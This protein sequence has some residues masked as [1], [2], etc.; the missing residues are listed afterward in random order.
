MTEI[1]F[2]SKNYSVGLTQLRWS[3]NE[4][5]YRFGNLNLL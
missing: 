1:N 3:I 5:L 2:A 4:E